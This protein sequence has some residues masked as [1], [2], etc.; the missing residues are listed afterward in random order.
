MINCDASMF[1][2]LI[3]FDKKR[4]D[5]NK[6][7]CVCVCGS[8]FVWET[9]TFVDLT[10]TSFVYIVLCVCVYVTWLREKE[11]EREAELSVSF[12][13][14]LVYPIRTAG[15]KNFVIAHLTHSCVYSLEMY[16]MRL[17]YL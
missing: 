7:I 1:A 12:T 5:T 6:R 13:F 8:A 10:Y 17:N 11:R 4:R 3:S 2:H 9:L 16:A 15:Y 14:R